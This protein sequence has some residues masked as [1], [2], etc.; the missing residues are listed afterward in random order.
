MVIKN[1]KMACLKLQTRI[2][3]IFSSVIGTSS[4]PTNSK[5]NCMKL[6]SFSQLPTMP[7]KFNEGRFTL[8]GKRTFK[9]STSSKDWRKVRV[10]CGISGGVDSAVSALL[11]K[12]SGCEVVGIF[13]KNWDVADETG[14]CSG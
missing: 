13:M 2:R 11:L 3:Q 8:S 9:T 14:I 5:W 12:Q 6:H 1:W 10:A 7:C 4:G